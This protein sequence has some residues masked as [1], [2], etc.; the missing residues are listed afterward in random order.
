ML[1]NSVICWQ[2][3]VPTRFFKKLTRTFIIK[4]MT[5]SVFHK[6][7]IYMYSYAL[8]ECYLMRTYC[9]SIIQMN[10]RYMWIY[11]INCHTVVENK[12]LGL[13]CMSSL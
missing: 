1:L 5:F 3:H 12:H 9:N 7:I 6:H 13:I 10:E 4:Y 2:I 11:C 8:Q